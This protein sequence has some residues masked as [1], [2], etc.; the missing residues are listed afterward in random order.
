MDLPGAMILC[1]VERDQHTPVESAEHVEATVK[2]PKLIDGFGE[3]RMQQRRRGR[4]EHVP[5]VIVQG[6]LAMPN[7][8]AQLER[9]CP[10]SNRR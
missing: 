1:A 10:S 3:D 5:N 6:I 7:R 8:L 2:S 9:P 4:I